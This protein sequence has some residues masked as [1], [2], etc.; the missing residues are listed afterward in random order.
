MQR[1]ITQL[2]LKS[3]QVPLVEHRGRAYGLALEHESGWKV[4]YSGDT[5]PCDAL[6]EAGKGATLLIHEATLEDDKPDVAAAKGHS[7]FAQAIDIG[8]R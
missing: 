2:K 7:T 3:I 4:V 6:V 1:L 5:K 8:R